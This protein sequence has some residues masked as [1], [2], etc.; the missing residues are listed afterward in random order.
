MH[1]LGRACSGDARVLGIPRLSVH[2][3][4]FHLLL[5]L[6]LGVLL[7][8]YLLLLLHLHLHIQLPVDTETGIEIRV[9][10]Y[11]PDGHAAWGGTHHVWRE[12][13]AGVH[14][15]VVTEPAHR[16]T[17]GD[18]AW[19]HSRRSATRTHPHCP[20]H[21]LVVSWGETHVWSALEHAHGRI[22][23]AWIGV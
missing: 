8:P 14:L 6:L 3:G 7:H 2:H 11:A 13:H 12:A 16:H 22:W 17:T 21:H 23:A 18:A 15:G 9:R 10:R 4:H 1:E 5:P 20:R 19:V